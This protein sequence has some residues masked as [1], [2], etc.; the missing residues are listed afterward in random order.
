MKEVAHEKCAL[1]SRIPHATNSSSSSKIPMGWKAAFQ[2]AFDQAAIGMALVGL[3]GAWLCVNSALCEIVGYSE[4]ELLETNFQQITH[5]G[6]LSADLNYVAQM[7]RGEIRSYQMEKRYLAKDG[8]TVF[9]LLSVSLVYRDKSE[10][11]F[12]FSQIQD[13]TARKCAEERLHETEKLVYA[14]LN[15][16]P[17]PVFLKDTEGRYL[18]VNKNFERVLRVSEEQIRGKKD[19]EVFPP[20]QAAAFRSNDLQVLQAGV[21]LQFEE[22]ALHEDGPH[23]SIVHKFPLF[24]ADGK[25]YA[26]GGISTDITERKRV[27]DALRRSEAR[28]REMVENTSYGVYHATRN[29]RF[30]DVNPALVTMLGYS[31]KDALLAVSLADGIYHNLEDRARLID[32]VLRTGRVM[33]AEV[34][35]KRK[36]GKPITV[37]ISGRALYDEAGELA[38]TEGIIENLTEWRELE[39]QFRQAQKMEAVG[40]LAGGVAHDFNNLLTIIK[41][42]NDLLSDHVEQSEPHRSSIEQIRKASDRAV[43]LTRQLLAFSRMQVLE[44]RVLN[45][46]AVVAELSKMLPR[47]IS[48]NIELVFAPDQAL[49]QVKAD[50]GQV[51]QVIMNLAVNARDAMP[52]GGKLV[53]E[54]TNFT[55]DDEYVRRHPAALPGQ[56][57][58][59][60]VTDTGHGMGTA[61]LNHIFEP[62]FTTKELGK[63]TGLGLATVYGIV[64]QSGGFIWVYSEPGKGTTFKIYLPRVD[65]PVEPMQHSKNGVTAA[66]GTETILL[67]EDEEALRELVGQFLRKNGYTVL[68]AKN[69][70]EGLLIAERQSG[71]IHL[72]MTDVVMPKMGGWELAKRLVV[73]RPGLKVVYMSGYSEYT[74]T[75]RQNEEW[76][77]TFVQKPF[78][79][80]VLARKVRDALERQDRT[81]L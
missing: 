38:G 31:S 4:Q 66:R 36:D 26:T 39:K 1:A 67:V 33:K 65:E 50:P 35:W 51:E 21:P 11:L 40:R 30:L 74:A 70:V 28:Y 5:P 14:L 55:M 79:M 61:T 69:G 44:P 80:A 53:V 56:Y 46:N 2:G 25:L 52:E 29:G 20:E 27:E 68:E 81:R 12:F 59:L 16:S 9:V 71:S 43:S 42:N 15:N 13:I 37:R 64:K 63:G 22:V 24:D 41:G 78:T 10:P 23:T 17:N 19:E 73:Q 18:L 54:T 60:A 77:E 6:D 57:V 7:V 48:E 47:L 76:R 3:D 72:L 8:H 45:L 49:G 75:P 34:E 58:M 32:Q 62:F